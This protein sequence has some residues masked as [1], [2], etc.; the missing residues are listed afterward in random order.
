M[1]NRYGYYQRTNGV[2]YALDLVTQRQTSLKTRHAAEAKRVIAAKNQAADTPQLNRAMAKVYASASSPELMERKWQEVIDAYAAKSVETT[3]P[4]VARAFR[5]VPFQ[6]I[7]S[8][9]VNETDASAFWKVLRHP[10]AGNSTNH[11]L[12]RLQNFAVAMRWMFEPVIP[13]PEWPKVKKKYT[14]AISAEEHAKILASETNLEHRLYYS[15]LWETGGSQSD[16]ACLTWK[17]IDR[18]EN[19]ISFYRDKLNE[20]EEEGEICGLSVLA[21]GIR[22]GEILAQCPQEGYLFPTLRQWTPAERTDTRC[23][24]GTPFA[25]KRSD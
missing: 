10:K 14:F 8:Q 4:R 22:L 2:Y 19:L 5:S 13:G 3:R 23:L 25:G 24:R 16:I 20:R 11:Y 17:R 9:K 21:I 18:K 1:K 6:L 7:A 15:M 12:H